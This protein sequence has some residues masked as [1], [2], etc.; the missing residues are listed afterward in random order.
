MM[1]KLQVLIIANLPEGFFWLSGYIQY[2]QHL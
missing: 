1:F 2:F